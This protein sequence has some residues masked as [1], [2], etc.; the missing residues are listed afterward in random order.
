M[1]IILFDDKRENLFPFTLTRPIAEIRWG[2]TTIKQKWEAHNLEVSC[3]TE[4]YLSRKFPCRYAREN[5]YV[6]AGL[7]PNPELL[8]KMKTLESEQAIVGNQGE[9]L[10][11]KSKEKFKAG[12]INC[13]SQL[14]A[15]F[16]YILL[17]NVWEI[18]GGNAENIQRD[19]QQ[20]TKGKTSQKL[21][22]SNILIG[23]NIF[24]EEG[25]KVEAAILNS[26]TGPI[27][28]GRN[29]EIME[30]SSIR[31]PF[32]LC[33]SAVVKM[34]AKIYGATT[35]GPYSKVGGEVGN[36]VIFGYSNKG[37][38]GFLGNSVLGE[39]CNLGADTNVSNLKNDYGNVKIWNYKKAAFL[40][41]G[42]QFCGL[43]MGDHSKSGINTMFNT[44]TV[45]G[46]NA[47]IFGSG[48]P[49]KYIPSFSWG[50]AAGFTEY[51]LEKALQVAER[52]M[53]RR[54]IPLT[55]D[56]KKILGHLHSFT[57]TS[58]QKQRL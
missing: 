3:L 54:D 4:T 12:D 11:L 6:N 30:G 18:F 24:I 39:W 42:Q 8:G 47:N 25:A 38:D 33:E 44:G 15:D 14:K 26:S 45:V 19:F 51:R 37:H 23:D 32:A 28:I 56:D 31:G 27:Y 55:T 58:R 35:V 41:T 9:I 10:V 50:G 29:A 46:V 49:E 53:S 43:M 16:S 17:R 21:S 34:S 20:L 2:I 13:T 22:K 1:N 7:L 5:F 57:K 40:D 36:S 52:V 48:F